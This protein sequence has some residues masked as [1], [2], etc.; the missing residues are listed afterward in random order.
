MQG[1]NWL[2]VAHRSAVSKPSVKVETFSYLLEL[3]LIRS[4]LGVG[5]LL[6]TQEN[7]V[8]RRSIATTSYAEPLGDVDPPV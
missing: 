1:R 3:K 4:S 2:V 8:G 5:Y 6:K 7:W